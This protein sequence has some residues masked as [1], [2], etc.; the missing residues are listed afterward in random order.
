MLLPYAWPARQDRS[1]P[2]C[3]LRCPAAEAERTAGRLTQQPL[4]SPDEDQPSFEARQRR[5]LSRTIALPPATAGLHT[6]PRTRTLPVKPKSSRS[7]N[8]T[9]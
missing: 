3:R 5:H 8:S 9:S 6:T 1:D 4:D 7:F 2:S